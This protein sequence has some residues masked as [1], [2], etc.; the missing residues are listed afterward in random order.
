LSSSANNLTADTLVAVA[1]APGRG[2]VGIVRVSGPAVRAI[3]AAVLGSALPAPRVASLV[4]FR[5]AAGDTLDEGL[6]LFFEGPHSYTGEDVLELQGHGGPVV[7][8]QLVARC[9]ALGA[10]RAGPGEFTQRAFLNDK[11]DLAQAEAVADLIDAGSTAAARAAVRSLQGEFSAQVQALVE[12][13]IE[14][15]SWVEAAIDFPEEEI[16]FLADRALIE[17]FAALRG[18]FADVLRSAQQGRVLRD[19]MTVVIAGRPNAGKSSLLNAL[20]GHEAAIV[21]PLAGTTR[22]VLRERIAIDGMPLHVIDTAGLRAADEAAADVV[23]AEGIRRARAEMGR[24][25][26]VLFL[27][28]ASADPQALAW[29]QERAGL[30]AGVPVTLLINK[31]DQATADVTK[32][33]AGAERVLAI[34][35]RTGAGLEALREHLKEIMGYDAG[36]A[37]TVSARAR[38]V[39]ALQ[40]AERHTETAVRQLTESRAGELVAEELR[41]AQ[42][43][44]N[45]ITGE[46]HADDLLGRIFGSFCIGK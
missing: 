7:L 9:V 10:R 24:A 2:G 22:D 33:A 17:R 26:R 32:V 43:A 27:I 46:F 1:T 15:R 31:I 37:G 8:E 41:A 6:A 29:Q 20:A 12:A 42:Q 28:D 23:E 18:R 34:S 39:E 36:A 40:R 5:D 11:L 21:T 19:G 3:G 13:L 16:D 44:L 35:A 38:H 30:P 25:D 45:E 4:R 14:L